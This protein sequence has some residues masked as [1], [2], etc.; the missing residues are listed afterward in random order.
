[1]QKYDKEIL[2]EYEQSEWPGQG[3]PA[4]ERLHSELSRLDLYGVFKEATDFATKARH[5]LSLQIAETFINVE[6]ASLSA[7]VSS[8]RQTPSYTPPPPAYD[9]TQHKKVHEVIADVSDAMTLLSDA[10]FYFAFGHE[11][12]SVCPAQI[13]AEPEQVK[14]FEGGAR[15]HYDEMTRLA[16]VL[17]ALDLIQTIIETNT[18]ART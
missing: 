6:G 12:G 11:L 1:M 3:P 10:Q 13:L 9:R 15:V 5:L 8:L 16:R 17:V 7:H 18:R 2:A 4:L 14:I